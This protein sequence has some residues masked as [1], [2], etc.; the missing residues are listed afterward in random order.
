M[1]DFG[2][3]CRIGPLTDVGRG[4]GLRTLGGMVA[5]L[6]YASSSEHIDYLT[7]L[8]EVLSQITST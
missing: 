3:L 2:D 5:S 4:K 6:S 8:S 7:F 1:S